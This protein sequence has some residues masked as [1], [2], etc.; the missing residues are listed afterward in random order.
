[1]K[2]IAILSG[3]GGTGKSTFSLLLGKNLAEEGKKVLLCDCDVECPNDYILSG[4]KIGKARKKVF[5]LFPKLDKRKC[6]KCGLCQKYCHNNAIFAPPGHYPIFLKD[7]CSGCGVCWKVCPF[8]AIKPVRE[9]VGRIFFQKVWRNFFLLTGLLKVNSERTT[10]VL[11]EAKKLS[12]EIGKKDSFSFLIFDLPAG[13]HCPVVKGL[14]GADIVYVV[15]EATPMGLHDLNLVLILLKKLKILPKVIL[16]RANLGKEENFVKILKGFGIKEY[17]KIPYS[18]E[19]IK[20]YSKG[21]LL[22]IS[23]SFFNLW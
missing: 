15:S 3:K 10:R 2:K 21:Q 18:D 13:T 5:S 7:F 8:G 12:I 20:N 19:V 1:M 6:R 11:E 14:E 17:K 22:N 23:S 9:E 16:N 4:S